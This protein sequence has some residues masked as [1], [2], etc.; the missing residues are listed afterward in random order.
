MVAPPAKKSP[1]NRLVTAADRVQALLA[2]V[3]HVI[4]DHPPASDSVSAARARG[5]PLEHGGKSL[6]M[7][8]DRG[9]GFAIL[10][11]GGD[12]R[13]DN[14]AL[15]RHLRVRRYRFATEAELKQITGLQ[16]GCV[17]PFGRPVFDVPLLVDA[18]TAAR[19]RIAF[20]LASHT[21]SVVMATADWLA[22]AKP[23][24]VFPFT[25]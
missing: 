22:V 19:D 24:Q 10:V 11:V 18:D 4:L 25:K 2:G 5:T 9:I 13:I 6:L 14:A 21:R 7:K 15:R 3:P 1:Y 23:D 17:P 20:S 12:R 16:P 8:L